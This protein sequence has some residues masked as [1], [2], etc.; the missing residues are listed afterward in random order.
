M[1]T[2]KETIVANV[3]RGRTILRNI[4]RKTLVNSIN[5][6]GRLYDE[7]VTIKMNDLNGGRLKFNRR[8][9]ANIRVYIL[10]TQHHNDNTGVVQIIAPF[11]DKF[12]HYCHELF[13]QGGRLF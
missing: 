7:L 13:I 3:F 10:Y 1:R 6:Y 8:E 2:L 4:V 5:A 11:D 9:F 12:R